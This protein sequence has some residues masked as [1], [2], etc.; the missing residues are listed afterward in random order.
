MQGGKAVEL[1]EQ[2]V[3]QSQAL[4]LVLRSCWVKF[5]TLHTSDASS[6]NCGSWY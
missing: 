6:V 3:A 4:T 2:L 5:L 1:D